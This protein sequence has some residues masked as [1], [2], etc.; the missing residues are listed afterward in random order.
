MGVACDLR[1][2][3][4]ATSSLRAGP[5]D[6][7][8]SLFLGFMMQIFSL[9]QQLLLWYVTQ[10]QAL[11]LFIRHL[12]QNGRPIIRPG[13]LGATGN[14]AIAKTFLGFRYHCNSFYHIGLFA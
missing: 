3:E 13:T 10:I 9:T 5:P 1:W 6:I 14:S 2:M 4:G 12:T 11:V 7:N 8:V